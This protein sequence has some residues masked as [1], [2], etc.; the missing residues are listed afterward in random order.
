M[1][2]VRHSAKLKHKTFD[3]DKS[4]ITENAILGKN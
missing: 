2:Q 1:K 4:T 3:D